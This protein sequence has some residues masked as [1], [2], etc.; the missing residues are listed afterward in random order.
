MIHVK[1]NTPTNDSQF[2]VFWNRKEERKT[3]CVIQLQ[4]PDGKYETIASGVT[5]CHPKLDVYSPE[6]G[7]KKSLARALEQLMPLEGVVGSSIKENVRKA[8]RCFWSAYFNRK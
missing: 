7:R 5:V 3:I 2:R 1:L 4:K 8:K 6:Q